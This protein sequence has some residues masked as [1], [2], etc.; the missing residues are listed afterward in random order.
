MSF[1]NCQAL[2][3]FHLKRALASRRHTD[4]SVLKVLIMQAQGTRVRIPKTHMGM[5]ANL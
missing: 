2:S 5:V 1:L 4:G 3:S